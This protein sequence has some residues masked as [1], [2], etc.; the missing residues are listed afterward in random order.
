MLGYFKEPEL[1]AEMFEDGWLKTG[2]EG[3]I[4]AEGYF[5]ITGRIKDQFKTSK[6]KYVIPAAI[7]SKVL[8]H[9][10]VSQACVVGSGMP[11][12]LLLCT[13]SEKAQV[14]EQPS[15]IEHLVELLNTIN[16]QL[17]QHEK[18]TRLIVVKEE[19]TIENGILTPTLKIKRK[20]IEQL[21]QPYYDTWLNSPTTVSFV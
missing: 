10:F 4:D 11:A 20:I 16:H 1:T 8:A 21:F 14:E 9:P 15:I 7:E 2:D 18:I 12:P 17:E 13:L 19:W 3:I 6:G 5:T